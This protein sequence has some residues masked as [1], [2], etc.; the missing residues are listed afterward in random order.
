MT[1]ACGRG[2]WMV[3]ALSGCLGTP[4]WP[5][6]P[7]EDGPTAVVLL[8]LQRDF[9]EDHGR[10]PI[11][12]TQVEPLLRHASDVVAEARARGLPVVRIHNAFSRADVVGNLSRGGAA[13][14]G[15]EG[16]E[17]DPRVPAGEDARFDKQWPDA[18]TNPDVDAWVR[19]H[20][21]RRLVIV[22]VFADQCVEATARAA[23]HRLL[24]VSVV[25]EGV[26]AGSG[27]ARDRAL[28]RL[29][30][31]GVEVVDQVSDLWFGAHEAR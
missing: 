11:E 26:G 23:R 2:W 18:F 5:V 15:S 27:E 19:D 30:A 21:V 28:A 8:D 16:A 12:R 14:E 25:R 9:L 3:V 7:G 22:G 29:A 6:D 13:V 1:R 20:R 17:A 4:G 31:V 24:E 10:M